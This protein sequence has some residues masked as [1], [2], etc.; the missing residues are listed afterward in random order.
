MS[1]AWLAQYTAPG[2]LKSGD[3]GWPES[4]TKIV[5]S[6]YSHA[7]N[8]AN[9]AAFLGFDANCY[10]LLP[11]REFRRD[12]IVGVDK[13]FVLFRTTGRFEMIAN[14]LSVDKN[15]DLALAPSFAAVG[16]PQS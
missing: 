3:T 11:G 10:F 5:G 12:R 2:A 14:F 6:H 4:L 16:D 1:P 7:E 13:T 8:A 9:L 15:V